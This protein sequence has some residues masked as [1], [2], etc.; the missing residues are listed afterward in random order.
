VAKRTIT[1]LI[2]KHKLRQEINL[3]FNNQNK[4]ETTIQAK[5]S[6]SSDGTEN[7]PNTDAAENS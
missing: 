1:L 7:S 3:D 4:K 6:D 5:T 2:K